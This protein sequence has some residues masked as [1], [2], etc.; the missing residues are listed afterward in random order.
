MTV[1]AAGIVDGIRRLAG[2]GLQ[3]NLAVSL[4]AAEQELR[5][6]LMPLA[7]A[8]PLPDLISA[9][10]DYCAQTGRMITLEYVLLE[11]VNDSPEDAAALAELASRLPCKINLICY[12]S[13]ESELFRPPGNKK[14]RL[15][16]SQLRKSCP[17]VV[18]RQSRGDDIS[19]GCGQ[20][21]IASGGGLEE[22]RS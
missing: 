3:V 13:I 14:T 19:A 5:E 18:R 21:H 6:G 15:F 20:L 16:L 8:N 1:S 7:G 12:N 2:E 11:G 4:N 22:R 17:T 9:L 10:E